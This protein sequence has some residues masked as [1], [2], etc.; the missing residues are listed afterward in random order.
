MPEIS[1]P[2][3]IVTVSRYDVSCLPAGHRDYGHFLIEVDRY[4]GDRG[5]LWTVRDADGRYNVDGNPG[6]TVLIPGADELMT[7]ETA[8]AL[9]QR[10]APTLVVNGRTVADVLA[11]GGGQ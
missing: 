2:D 1:T 8:L 9:A 11:R 5:E 3:P 10:L 4:T 7:V 6:G